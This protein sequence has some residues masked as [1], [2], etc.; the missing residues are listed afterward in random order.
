MPTP[1][2]IV[3]TAG[4]VDHGKTALITALTGQELDALAEEQARGIT[5]ALGFTSAEINGTSVSFID[6]PGHE[7]LVR[8]MVAGA[9]GMDAVLLCVS[10][11]DGVMPQTVEHVGICESLGIRSGIVVLTMADQ[12]DSELLELAQADVEDLV[13]GTFLD[14]APVIGVSSLTGHGMP[15]LRDAIA[16][17]TPSERS[18]AGP[19]RLP[20]DRVFSRS[21]FGT[22]ASGTVWSGEVRLDRPLWL[23]PDNERVRVRGMHV[24]GVSVEHAVAGQ[25]LAVNIAGAP[26]DA[27]HRG[28]TLASESLPTTHILDAKLSALPRGESLSDGD[29]V[30]VL[31]GTSEALGRVHFAS[32]R[33]PL[34]PGTSVYAQLRLDTPLTCMQGDRFIVRRPSPESTLAG[35]VVLDPWTRRMRT[36]HKKRALGELKRLESGDRTVLL[37][38]ADEAGL[39]EAEVRQRGVSGL[40][41][42]LADHRFAASVVGRFE[43]RLLDMMADYHNTHPLS[44]GAKRRELHRDGVGHLPPRVFDAL[45]ERLAD[46]GL[47][48]ISGPLVRLKHFEVRLN[49]EQT[50]LSAQILAMVEAAGL[51][52]LKLSELTE[53]LASPEVTALLHLH[54]AAGRVH[55]VA[56]IGWFAQSTLDALTHKV[57][58]WF[59]DNKTLDA[60][61]FKVL[62][63]QSRRTA[64]PLLEW[65]DASGVTARQGDSRKLR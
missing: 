43:G 16:K 28:V 35:G 31:L 51:D 39:T 52:G 64:I 34:V 10:A 32:E 30:R 44:L 23:L 12:V 19:F 48:T 4:H 17:L 1:G 22:I 40:G 62:S 26:P 49:D 56:D 2:P 9:A 14:S 37:E 18:T 53:T 38:R 21:G 5:I 42:M 33:D 11:V 63:G 13:S 46:A 29:A 58:T 59:K 8:T 7:S 65:L 20:V 45:V 61:A 6:V 24:H 15:A 50:A 36:K 54:A 60:Q 3:G 47:A 57:R 25:R 55:R 27:L 41:L